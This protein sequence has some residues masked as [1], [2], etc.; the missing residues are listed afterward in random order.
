MPASYKL[1]VVNVIG[2]FAGIVDSA[3]LIE[4]NAVISV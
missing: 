3:D 1:A 4:A 2:N